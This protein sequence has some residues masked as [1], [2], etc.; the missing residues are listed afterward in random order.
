MLMKVKVARK[1]RAGV[2]VGCIIDVDEEG[3]RWNDKGRERYPHSNELKYGGDTERNN[4]A[5]KVSGEIVWN[6]PSSAN[7]ELCFSEMWACIS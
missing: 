2:W 6:W 3:S 4:R 7:S 1:Y 5:R